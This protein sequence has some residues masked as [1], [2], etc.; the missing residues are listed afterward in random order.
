[1]WMWM[2]WALFLC[3]WL[4]L[5][6]LS[7]SGVCGLLC[8]LPLSLRMTLRSRPVSDSLRTTAGTLCKRRLAGGVQ[9]DPHR[10]LRPLTAREITRKIGCFLGCKVY[11]AVFWAIERTGVLWGL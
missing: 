7:L 10:R 5:L 8:A 6:C 3:L 1:M 9:Y 2:L 4:S 11:R